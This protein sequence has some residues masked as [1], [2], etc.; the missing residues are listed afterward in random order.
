MEEKELVISYANK[1]DAYQISLLEKECFSVPWS[2]AS[3]IESIEKDY[4]IF[5]KAVADKKI[6]GYAGLYKTFEEGDI[7]NIAVSDK[8]RRQGIGSK[9]IDAVFYEC[10]KQKISN[11]MLEVRKSNAMAIRLYEKKGFKCIGVRKGFYQKPVEDAVI[12]KR[13]LEQ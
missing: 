2:E 4:S 3:I 6:V 5:L 10:K 11:I 13:E 7:T 12:M 9:L 1:S 8:Y